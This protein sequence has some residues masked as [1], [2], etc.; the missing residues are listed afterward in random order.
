MVPAARRGGDLCAFMSNTCTVGDIIV[1]KSF[2][3]ILSNKLN[4]Q[5]ITYIESIGIVHR[6]TFK[7]F[8]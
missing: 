6:S 4:R 7:V 8:T 1:C 3:C 2:F 5:H